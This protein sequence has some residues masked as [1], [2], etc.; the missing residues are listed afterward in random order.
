MKKILFGF[1]MLVCSSLAFAQN[2]DVTVSSFSYLNEI[3]ANSSFVM[4]N[5]TFSSNIVVDAP[6]NAF[7]GSGYF[8]GNGYS[9][10][11]DSFEHLKVADAISFYDLTVKNFY[12]AVVST[13]SNV[14]C[15]G[16]AVEAVQV[17]SI[18][19]SI[20]SSN[21]VHV[22]VSI[23]T[24]NTA[25][26]TGGAF[27]SDLDTILEN[28]VF[29][30]NL[31][32]A[33][34][35]SSA[36]ASGGV[37]TNTNG[38]I[39]TITG[40]TFTYNKAV[41]E[42]SSDSAKAYGGAIYNAGTAIITNSYFAFNSVSASGKTAS[43][44]YGGAIYNEG[45]LN[46][47]ADGANIIFE[48]NTAN[49]AS[50]AIYNS[51][52]AVINMQATAGGEIIFNDAITGDS[53]NVK[54]VINILDGN[55][56]V[57]NAIT[58][59]DINIQNGTLTLGVFESSTSLIN[60]SRGSIGN[61]N[62][63]ETGLL[64]IGATGVLDL[65]N[66]R[67]D[68]IV[69][70]STLTYSA[71]AK[72]NLE[73]DLASLRKDLIYVEYE[74]IG[75]GKIDFSGVR[76]LS[77]FTSGIS[78]NIQIVAT[79]PTVNYLAGTDFLVNKGSAVY[80]VVDVSSISLNFTLVE[81]SDDPF[82]LNISSNGIRTFHAFEDYYTPLNYSAVV[83]TG[84][85]TIN[86]TDL[87]GNVYSVNGANIHRIFHVN[88]KDT[89][90]AINDL[91]IRNSLS[92]H[93]SAILNSSGTVYIVSSTFQNNT[94][95][96]TETVV[97]AG[98]AIYN[99]SYTYVK[100]SH[101]INNTATGNNAQGGAIYN[102][103]AATLEI[104]GAI[105]SG[106]TVSGTDAQGGAIYNEGIIN[107]FAVDKNIEFSNN[108]ANGVS[109]AIFNVNGATLNMNADGAMI[110]FNDAIASLGDGNT[111]NINDVSIA[112]YVDGTI[113]INADMSAFGD[114]SAYTGN[115]VNLYS[116]TL[117]FGKNA[118]FF[119]NTKFNMYAGSTLNLINSSIDNISS[120]DFNLINPGE[121]YLK[122][123]VD[124]RNAAADNFIGTVINTSNG[125]LVI[126]GINLLNDFA[127]LN[128]KANIEIADEVTLINAIKLSDDMK[129][130]LGPIFLYDVDY[131]NGFLSFTYANDFNP[132]VFI[133]PVA[134]HIGG[135]LEQLNSYDYAFNNIEHR[136]INKDYKGLWVT[137]YY[138]SED[139]ELTDKLTVKNETYGAYFGYDTVQSD[140]WSMNIS[141]SLYGAFNGSKQT[142]TGATI[143]KSG[144]M[145]GGTA[146][147]FGEKFYTALTVNAGVSSEHGEGPSGTE[148]FMMYTKGI[149]SRTGY[150]F[151]L[152]YDEKYKLIPE[153]TLSM[154]VVDMAP[155]GQTTSVEVTSNGMNPFTLEPSVKFVA[156]IS[157]DVNTF[158]K[159]SYIYPMGKTEF[160]A[161]DVI[162]P[163][164]TIDSYVQYGVGVNKKFSSS[165]STKAEVFGRSAGRTGF[166]G[167]INLQ[168][169]FGGAY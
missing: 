76:I 99:S 17:V 51:S 65:R 9:L 111:I 128:D 56:I 38:K 168:F 35:L 33:K 89:T 141:F 83:A 93:G 145:L 63:S 148:T 101:F 86:G 153:V 27:H 164:L 118:V 96:S 77:N 4:K 117:Q 66:N 31:A 113:F 44:A 121:S 11:G 58:N 104:Q 5:V 97:I 158:A 134:M 40:S 19:D 161:N 133:V 61:A 59:N 37:F 131:N 142:Y 119:N 94:A 120:S 26:S 57:N 54:G 114:N 107:L 122:I 8:T 80:H 123:D 39:A 16:G 157:N 159:V 152:S 149:A 7:S 165:I 88:S 109:N 79:W 14:N 85:L 75:T 60:S 12:S 42:S 124:L 115:S 166:G 62:I 10:D 2:L 143:D 45:I 3:A 162:L 73:V 144:G 74:T 21:T 55:V 95:K 139:I 24:E 36:T 127:S 28:S 46:L 163:E 103:A 68:D 137:P 136:I 108:K 102:E 116:G 110:I 71:G 106:N 15:F 87:E 130:V 132:S 81:Y 43:A 22:E 167:S 126:N 53:N 29:E 98:G 64:K 78:A 160:K 69:Y 92:E 155:Y 6:F 67:A 41:A 100:D 72:I 20:F 47:N 34:A 82:Q 91:I 30:H 49:G 1:V 90:L 151:A 112:S 52:G 135:F 50:N 18:K 154:S 105:F 48:G 147:L 84:T 32:S 129:K 146:L 140:L 169:R 138:N 125:T 13:N 150:N 156:D 70:L 25:S 23:S